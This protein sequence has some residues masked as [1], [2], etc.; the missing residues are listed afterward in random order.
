MEYTDRPEIGV[1]TGNF[2]IIHP[3]YIKLFKELSN[4]CMSSFVLLHIDPTIERPEKCK[5]IFSVEER[6]E[7]I[8][9]VF[10]YELVNFLYYNTE[11]ELY[12]ILKALRPNIRLMG[13][14]YKGKSFT[15]DDLDIPIKWVDR[16][17]GWS[18]T[19]VKKLLAETL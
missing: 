18:T 1:I 17:H 6:V 4:S 13:E 2:D 10:D 16:S 12:N 14:D 15:G 5:P 7:T 9:A 11:E 8:K 3:G 19:K